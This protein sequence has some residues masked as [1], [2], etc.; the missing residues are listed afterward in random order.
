MVARLMGN[1]HKAADAMQEIMM[2]LWNKRNQIAQHPNI[3]GF[4]VLTA[5]NYCLDL[6]KKK[7]STELEIDAEF[8]ELATEAN[9]GEL[10]WRE[11]KT[12]VEK[13][14]SQLPLPQREAM[15]LRDIDGLEYA[16]I[17]ETMN[18]KIDHIRVLLSRARKK[19]ALELKTKYNY[20]N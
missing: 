14:L 4:V 15:L 1:E 12:I 6:L 9:E 5:R 20:E 19:V 10:E 8:V 11:L 7:K 3:A 17:A 13:I 2:K 18:L 16:E